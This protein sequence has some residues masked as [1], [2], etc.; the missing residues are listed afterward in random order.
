M[1]LT[2][3]VDA[4]AIPPP[5]PEPVSIDLKGGLVFY[6][7]PPKFIEQGYP[8]SGLYQDGE[9]VYTIDEWELWSSSRAMYF[10]DDAM[11]FIV[12]PYSHAENLRFFIRGDNTNNYK[13]QSL[14][15][16]G[17]ISLGERDLY[18]AARQWHNRDELKH[19]RKNDRLHIMTLE[20]DIITFDLTNGLI[21]SREISP[22]HVP[23]WLKVARIAIPIFLVL[24]G[25]L[26]I[27]IIIIR[28]KKLS[29]RNK[30]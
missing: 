18:S 1:M 16:Y 24:G 13:A 12:V 27:G 26:I 17:A 30:D 19:D 7:T 10:S 29:L 14:L 28:V 25:L 4:H 9:L 11:S 23:S 15:R 20:G 2:F 22:E 8:R 5:T 6:L 3:V 21:I